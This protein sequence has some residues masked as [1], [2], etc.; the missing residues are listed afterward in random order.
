MSQGWIERLLGG[1]FLYYVL[2]MTWSNLV[3]GNEKPPV[4]FPIDC[5]V[6][7]YALP[8]IY[9]VA[10]WT[11]YK[12]S[13]AATI[14]EVKRPLFYRFASAHTINEIAAQH[15]QLPISLVEK[16]KTK[17]GASV[18]CTLEYFEYNCF[19]ET[20]YLKPFPEND[21]SL[22]QWRYRCGNQK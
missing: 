14:C 10:G 18:C 17:R 13:K 19:V 16:R 2:F 9:Y 6:G 21:V 20:V 5:L 22:Q 1:Q 11:L 4:E 3:C 15:L 7:K 8:V 12:A